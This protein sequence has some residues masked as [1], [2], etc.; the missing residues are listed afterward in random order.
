MVRL[1]GAARTMRLA[2]QHM[3]EIFI[4]AGPWYT[5]DDQCNDPCIIIGGCGRSGTTLL[6]EMLN[7]HPAIA[8]GPETAFL[9]DRINPRR[10]AAEWALDPK[11]IEAMANRSPSLVRFAEAFFREHAKRECKP[12]WADKTPRNVRALPRILSSF[13]YAQFIHVVRDGRDVACSLRN[14]PK[15]TVRHGKAIAANM[16][17]PIWRGATR[18]FKDTSAGL[19]FKDHPRCMEVRYERLITAPEATLREVCMFIEEPFDER[20]LEAVTSKSADSLRLLNNRDANQP[21]KH[22]S[23]NRWR[24]DMS[25]D[26]RLAFHRV[27][28]ELLIAMGY[29]TDARWIDD[30]VSS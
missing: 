19:A 24:R 29:A 25:R 26:E 14:H 20:M 7:R 18:W 17:R 9:C 2:R 8:C 27:A 11:L 12:R 4:D 3:R 16:N 13:P 10:V 22:T 6:R 5:S 23:M 15:E 21:I 30:E 28:G 1:L